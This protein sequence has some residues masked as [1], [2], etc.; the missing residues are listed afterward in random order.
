MASVRV[1]I[2][3]AVG[4]LALTQ[5]GQAQIDVTGRW[6][7]S[8]ADTVYWDSRSSAISISSRADRW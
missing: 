1:A 2:L 5:P 6:H 3:I 4:A 8:F 7:G